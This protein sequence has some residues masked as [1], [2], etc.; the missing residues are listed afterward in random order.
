MDATLFWSFEP[1]YLS[2]FLSFLNI[3]THGIVTVHKIH[4]FQI[5]AAFSFNS[6]GRCILSLS[7]VKNKT[8]HFVP[9]HSVTGKKIRVFPLHPHYYYFWLTR[10][11][12][13]C[14]SVWISSTTCFT[15]PSPGLQVFVV[16]LP[17]V[18]NTN[19]SSLY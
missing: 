3:N 13:L 7:Y 6:Y 2:V 18:V 5:L 12:P 1:D 4:L 15:T 17:H 11:T 14:P 19:L 10:N 8:A 9:I 16:S